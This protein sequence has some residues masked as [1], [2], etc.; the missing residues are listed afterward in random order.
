MFLVLVFLVI[1]T[2][3]L[4]I[5]QFHLCLNQDLHIRLV[6]QGPL[7]RHTEPWQMMPQNK[8]GVQSPRIEG[9]FPTE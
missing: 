7:L 5:P 1:C 9:I 6:H 2:A 3:E 4:F 8:Q